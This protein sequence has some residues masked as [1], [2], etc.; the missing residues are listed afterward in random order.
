MSQSQ[1]KSSPMKV[2]S[3]NKF[4]KVYYTME[5]DP[6]NNWNYSNWIG[7]VTVEEVIKGCELGLQFMKGWPNDKLLNDN[8]EISGPWS[9]ANEWIA[10]QWMPQ[11][12]KLGLKKF[13]HIVSPN[14]FSQ[15]SAKQLV[16]KIEAS[17]FEMRIFES[18]KD[19]ED[20][21]RG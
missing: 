6:I 12:L 8:S 13:A 18:R 5:H 7:F 20:W 10:N 21:L 14:F 16:T 1:L 4:N 3:R 2:E 11:A 19:A 17:N 15:L 9:G